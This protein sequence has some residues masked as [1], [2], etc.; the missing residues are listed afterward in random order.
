MVRNDIW[1]SSFHIH[2]LG[3]QHHAA[4][5]LVQNAGGREHT[6]NRDPRLRATPMASCVNEVPSDILAPAA[7]SADCSRMNDPSPQPHR[8]EVCGP[9]TAL[10]KSQ[11]CELKNSCCLSHY[12][13][14]TARDN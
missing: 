4:K 12:L 8:E 7:L 9:S 14:F 10:G 6:E 11:N 2:P 1:G 5:T 13:L 3:T